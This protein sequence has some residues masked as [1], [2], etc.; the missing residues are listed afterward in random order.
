MA[1]HLSPG[2]IILSVN[3]CPVKGSRDW[4][5]C[6]T[7]VPALPP[8]AAQQ[9]SAGS[10]SLV[11]AKDVVDQL[12][13]Q[14]PY[15]GMS[16]NLISSVS[17]F[18]TSCGTTDS[19]QIFTLSVL[20]KLPASRCLLLQ[21]LDTAYQ[22]SSRG[23]RQS[24]RPGRRWTYVLIMSS[25]LWSVP[26]PTILGICKVTLIVDGFSPLFSLGGA[27]FLKTDHGSAKDH[28]SQVQLLPSSLTGC[29]I[30]GV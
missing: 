13:R 25:A 6:L 10:K 28:V 26:I 24:A 22:K 18:S 21:A 11:S 1:A 16:G 19:V 4:L 15:R 3:L 12:A 7:S 23:V 27:L 2:D 8:H 20:L 5:T 30:W 17:L 14:E 29:W 9:R